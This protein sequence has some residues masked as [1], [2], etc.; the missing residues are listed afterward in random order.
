[1]LDGMTTGH[2]F[3]RLAALTLLLAVWLASPAAAQAVTVAFIAGGP[4]AGTAVDADAAAAEALLM[5]SL[6]GDAGVTWIDRATLDRV[7]REQSLSG[8]GLADAQTAA[9]LGGL[10]GAEAL[11]VFEGVAA[12]PEK[13][14]RLRVVDARTGAVL[15]DRVRDERPLP[16][17]LAAESSRFASAL[18]KAGKPIEERRYAAFVGVHNE[19]LAERWATSLPALALL[20][21]AGLDETPG[22]VMLERQRLQDLT[23]EAAIAGLPP[24]LRASSTLVEIGLRQESEAALAVTLLLSDVGGEQREPIRFQVTPADLGALRDAL[25]A[26]VAKALG[27]EWRAAGDGDAA[28]E[29]AHLAR[30]LEL[31]QGVNT[32]AEE[33]ALVEAIAALAP[34][35]QNLLRLANTI[36]YAGKAEGVSDTQRLLALR[37]EREL[38]ESIAREAIR[39]GEFPGVTVFREP[40]VLDPVEQEQIELVREIR[41]SNDTIYRLID[42]A[43]HARPESWKHARQPPRLLK[44]D[45]TCIQAESVEEFRARLAD[46]IAEFQKVFATAPPRDQDDDRSRYHSGLESVFQHHVHRRWGA[47]TTIEVA[48]SLTLHEDPL[49]RAVGYTTMLWLEKSFTREQRAKIGRE[50][51]DMIFSTTVATE[52]PGWVLDSDVESVVSSAA[53]ALGKAGTAAYLDELVQR[54]DRTKDPASL[55]RWPMASREL[56]TWIEEGRLVASED[57]LLAVC[58]GS[59]PE[60]LSKHAKWLRE[61]IH[62]DRKKRGFA[63]T[64]AGWE[65][66]RLGRIALSPPTA[67][68]PLLGA[69]IPEPGPSGGSL[70]LLWASRHRNYRSDLLITRMSARGG[71]QRVLGKL[72]GI[73]AGDAQ[74]GDFAADADTA[75]GVTYIATTEIGLL[76]VSDREV[77]A[78]APPAGP[79]ALRTVVCFR[80]QVYVGHDQGLDRFDP[81][82][83]T[84]HRLASHRSLVGSTP[85]DD[86]NRYVVSSLTVGPDQGRLYFAV[87]HGKAGGI[88]AFEPDT[89]R[90]EKVPHL[91]PGS[92]TVDGQDLVIV[93]NAGY[94]RFRPGVDEKPRAMKGY[95]YNLQELGRRPR[96]RH[97]WLPFGDKVFAGDRIF[98]PDGSISE[99][100]DGHDARFADVLG[101]LGAIVFLANP[102]GD[103][104]MLWSVTAR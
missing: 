41:A 3:C 104:H 102:H 27:A 51:L 99:L 91:S 67:T 18:E 43:Y 20:V 19:G 88:W 89:E 45:A 29:A 90:F 7:L 8:A 28:A 10:V 25:V 78:F 70:L 2:A 35:T 55:L 1:M 22:V 62:R 44:L 72:P 97:A 101:R 103:E 33:I 69:V 54:A 14:H 42:D 31:R 11:V 4:G 49:T 76:V 61:A 96:F 80:G 13:A 58:D 34:T 63:P 9:R 59:V 46:A 94:H 5:Q 15:T 65:G 16:D 23:R 21:R 24:A 82:T 100:P 57:R 38:S 73:G 12:G 17:W 47:A 52:N 26:E 84:F 64:P 32:P 6:G 87:E 60:E 92:L 39:R 66:Y 86:G 68:E 95:D 40:P 83:R 81:A 79:K 30:R 85:L 77:R 36:Y 37:R 74:D 98:G 75:E 48:Q 53:R 93:G 56:L 71:A 50:A